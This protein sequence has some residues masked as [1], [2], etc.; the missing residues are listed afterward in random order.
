M[1]QEQIANRRN[2]AIISAVLEGMNTP[3]ARSL[4]IRSL[5]LWVS[6]F[7]VAATARAQVTILDDPA[8][9]I[10]VSFNNTSARMAVTVKSTGA[11]W[12]NPSSG[13]GHT[14]A[15]TSIT[16]QD[17]T[18]L[19]AVGSVNG[20]SQV[21]I[22]VALTPSTGDLS[23]TLSADPTL[24]IAGTIKYPYAFYPPDGS[25]FAVM[26]VFGGHVV[27][28]TQ[29]TWSVPSSHSRLEWFGGV[30]AA[31]SGGWMMIASP[32]AD[33]E[34]SAETG[35]VAG[36]S[37]RGGAF[38]WDGSNASG[39][40]ANRFSYDRTAT[41]RFFASGGYVAQAKRFRLY[42]AE[43]GWLVT[44]AQKQQ[45]NPLV[46]SMLG[47]P[48]IYLWGDGRSTTML[49]ALSGAG[50]DRAMIQ[51]S[52]NHVDQNNAFPN[53]AFAGGSGWSSAVRAKGYIPGIYDIYARFSSAQSQPPNNGFFYLWPSLANPQWFYRNSDG[54]LDAQSSVSNAKAA[55]FARDTRLPAHNSIFGFEAYFSDVVCAVMPREDY[56]T[57][58]GHPATRSQ[59]IAGRQA[60][61]AAVSVDHNKIAGVEQLKSWAIP[62]AHWGEGMFWLG[63]SPSLG[64]FNNNVYP[65]ILTDVK[66]PGSAIASVLDVGWRVP[67]FELV[68]HDCVLAPVHWH[69][70]HNK[71]LYAWDLNDQ[72]ALLRGQ[73]PLLHLVYNGDQG[74]AGR[75]LTGATDARDNS[76]WDTRW[77]NQRVRDH[78]VRTYNT[79][80]AWHRTVGAL[81]MTDSRVLTSDFSVQLSEFSPDSGASGHGIIVNF[82]VYDGTFSMTGPTWAGSVR[83]RTFNVPAGAYVTYDFDACSGACRA[84]FDCSA[85]LSVQDIFGYLNAWFAGELRADWNGDGLSVQDL[86][87]FLN[88]WFAGC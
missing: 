14:V 81:E 60:L 37:R 6:V 54:T 16:Q 36:Q 56:D 15:L 40:V 11:I 61:L 38:K 88:D 55:T 46:S 33:M 86:F 67:L 45:F 77:T 42:A 17:A 3:A 58:F 24:S 70:A 27:P 53:Q 7:S 10:S 73:A 47:A 30:D 63:G 21:T 74:T 80:C 39:G 87:L 51:I 43:Q 23:V 31:M 48:V 71:L 2:T 79:V 20:A 75:A 49:D 19:T 41:I 69:R 44:L 8:S 66:A 22:R 62:Y 5:V 34:L 76:F 28:T 35:T 50:I 82:G 32:A 26:P 65:E 4:F 29:T 13:G 18:H 1:R 59:D 84:D 52:I 72:F 25:G 12:S 64:S 85:T 68:Y 57:T 78:V 83:G 9:P